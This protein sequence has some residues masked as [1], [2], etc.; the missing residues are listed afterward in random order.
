MSA[1][2]LRGHQPRV[3]R[4][5]GAVAPADA[6]AAVVR[7]DAPQPTSWLQIRNEEAAGGNQLRVYFLEADFTANANFIVIE[8]ASEYEGPAEVKEF[9]VRSVGGAIADAVA[10]FYMRRG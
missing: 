2:G 10:V 8:P 7:R 4:F 5:V 9:W 1:I 3:R 6:A